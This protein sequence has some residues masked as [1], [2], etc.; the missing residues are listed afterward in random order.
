[1]HKLICKFM[2]IAAIYVVWVFFF[3]TVILDS[4]TVIIRKKTSIAYIK[5]IKFETITLISIIYAHNY[6]CLITA[7]YFPW[8]YK[9][10]MV[11]S[12]SSVNLFNTKKCYF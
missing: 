3:F 2:C 4:L 1:M 12:I 10:N 11:T 8:N 6:Q 7:N 5:S 9:K